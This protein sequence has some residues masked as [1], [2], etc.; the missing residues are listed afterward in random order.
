M[1]PFAFS[2]LTEFQ[3]KT[4]T[5][6]YGEAASGKS[7][8]CLIAAAKVAKQ[9]RKVIFIDTEGSFSAERFKQIS[10]EPELLKNIIVADPS[11]FDEQK[12]AINKLPDL[13]S[14]QD[15]GLIVVDSLV[16][17]YRLEMSSSEDA[18]ATNRELSKQLAK[19]MKLAKKYKIPIVITNQ[20]YSKF[21]K[22]G[23]DSK[24]V[25]VGRDVL[26]YWT[27]I[28]I[29]LKKDGPNR[30][31]ELIRHK[32]KCEGCEINFR[33][34]QAGIEEINKHENGSKGIANNS[35]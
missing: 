12:I 3:P 31:A 1:T 23:E 19:L 25:P 5:Q 2:E 33:I 34:T 20:V 4:I 27:K 10:D 32:F 6:I 22:K 30:T 8:L 11:D 9:G 13:M 17:L 15:V 35:T 29:H 18:Y 14:E 24:L 26:K 28:V 21:S 7:N 16:S